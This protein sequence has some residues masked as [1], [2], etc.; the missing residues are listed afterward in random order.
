MNLTGKV[1]IQ[2]DKII[3]NISAVVSSGYKLTT[4]LTTLATQGDSSITGLYYHDSSL[5]GGAGD[6]SY[7]YAG[8]NPNNYVCFG[9]DEA[10]C[11]YENLYR[12]IGVIDGKVKL[13]SADV[14]TTDML[15]TN[16]EYN[17]VYSES[18]WSSTS[19]YYKGEVDFSTVGAYKWNSSI[20]NN[21]SKSYLNNTNLNRNFLTYLDSKNT[22]WKNMIADTTW[23][24]GGMT[25]TNGAQTNANTAYN[26]EVGVNKDTTTT[27]T[28]KIG[29]M[30]VSDYYYAASP[31][32]WTIGGYKYNN[33]ISKNWMYLGL[34]EWTISPVT[35][36][37]DSVFLVFGSGKI[38][39]T[40][41]NNPDAVRPVFNLTTSVQ[42]TGGTGTFTSPYRIS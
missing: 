6:N 3:D 10:T 21:W 11:P 15:G 23:Y 35:N 24:V 28:A 2:Q 22:K 1:L 12:I 36:Y 40:L 20:K 16:G 25:Q 42:Y 31:D 5:T 29:L 32:S 27:F 19:N 14:A 17:T 33:V 7:R 8:S 30:Y 18:I 26:Y 39:I 9:S 13:I 34:Y 38:A 37:T 4:A 41:V